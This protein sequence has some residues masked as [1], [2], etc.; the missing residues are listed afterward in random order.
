MKWSLEIVCMG[1][2]RAVGRAA[3][4]YSEV[5][6]SWPSQA[7]HFSHPV[8]MLKQC[9]PPQYAFKGVLISNSITL[10]KFMN[11]PNWKECIFSPCIIMFKLTKQKLK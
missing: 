10:H 6:G 1:M 11:I 8:T 2:G 3:K 5:P 7:A 4:W 9:T